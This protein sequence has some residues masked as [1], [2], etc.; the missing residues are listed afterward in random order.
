MSHPAS[1]STNTPR[2]QL[3]ELWYSRCGAATASAIAIRKHWLQAEFN[4][5]STVLRSL[6]DSDDRAILDSHYHHALSGLFREGGN[7]PP[8][9]ARAKGQETAVVGITWLD[10]YQG[11][12]TRADS[13]LRGIADLVG[14][15][16]ALP[17][18]DNLIDFQRGAAHHGFVTALGQIGATAKDVTFVD[19]PIAGRNVR[20]NDARRSDRSV[21]EL[22][23]LRG[24]A[25][26][27][28]FL[29]FA[30]GARAAQDPHLHQVLNL[31]DLKDPL[32]RVNNGTPRPVTVDRRFLEAQ[33][34]LV[35]RYLAVLIRTAAWA[36]Q[37]PSEVLD[38]LVSE[39]GAHTREDVVASH[40]PN[41][42]LSFT[43]K[44][45]DEYIRGLEVQKNFLR[46]Y[47]YLHADF[48]VQAWVVREPLVA[49]Q[50]LVLHESALLQAEPALTAPATVALSL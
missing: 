13:G 15:R 19:I 38:L 36:A 12:L 28:I 44:L 14:K 11:I 25:V 24:G 4:R 27:A 7:I 21:P 32:L 42:H 50:E 37:H 2:E 9:W 8:I 22:E 16:L 48:D 5:G 1:S 29:R 23:A 17:R 45:S 26:D 30:R 49:A 39:G 47:G 35:A 10:E 34:E 3:T 46:D 41:V 33:P 18:H 43:P 20:P 31:N 6:R 40:G